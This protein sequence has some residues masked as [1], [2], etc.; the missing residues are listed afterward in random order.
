MDRKQIF[1]G[2][3]LILVFFSILSV[4]SAGEIDNGTLTTADDDLNTVYGTSNQEDTLGSSIG[5]FTSLDNL[6]DDSSESTIYL[7]GNYTYDDGDLGLSEG[8]TIDK[9]ITI[10]GQGHTLNALNEISIF[11]IGANNHVILKNI[12][13]INGNA[14]FGAAIK[15]D[16]TSSLEVID[17]TFTGNTAQTSGGAIYVTN[18]TSSTSNV[19]IT[20]STFKNNDAG[21][22]GAVYLNGN[23]SVWSSIEDSAFIDC[24]ASGDGGAIY[25]DAVNVA[26]K[27]VAFTNNVVGDDGGAIYWQGNNGII[28]NIT[29]TSNR[30]ISA[31]K[32]DGVNTSSTRGGTICLTG[33]NVTIS[34]STFTSSSAYMDEGKDTSK[35]DG[36]ALFVT[37]NG[38]TIKDTAF[39]DCNATNNGG[40]VYVIGNG[41]I[42]TNCTF[43]DCS[44]NDGGVIYVEGNGA[45]INYTSITGSNAAG[46]GGA[47]YVDGDYAMLYNTRF[48][49][50]IAAD[51]GGAIYWTGS[52]GTIYNITCIND[53]GISATKPDGV[54]TSS[55]RGGAICLTGS[56]VTISE[57]SFTSC[58]AYMD[59]GKDTSKVDGG[60]LFITGNGVNI[61]GTTFSDC[62]ATHDGGAIY[63]IGNNTSVQSCT[64]EDSTASDGGAVFVAG[65]DASISASEFTHNSADRNAMG[66]GGS[67]Q[68]EGDRANVSGCSFDNS[69]AYV[70]GV[71]YVTGH[72]SVIDN[73][74]F[75][76]ATA[77]EGGAIYVAGTNASISKSGFTQVTADLSGGAI[78]VEGN[79]TNIEECNFT[80]CKA[81]Y[82][83]GGAIYIEGLNTTVNNTRFMKCTASGTESRG[84]A[85]DVNG[86]DT[87]IYNS[88]FDENRAITGGAIYVSGHRAL[89]DNSSFEKDTSNNG[90]AI[91]VFGENATITAS[92]IFDCNATANGGGIDVEGDG[93]LIKGT[94]LEKCNSIKGAGGSIYITG[95]YTTIDDSNFTKSTANTDGGAILVAGNYALINASNFEECTA[96]GTTTTNGGGAI[97]I[98]GE[99]SHI[100]KSN[101]TNNKV[102]SN[103]ACGGTIYIEGYNATIDGSYFNRS[104][105]KNKG[106]IIFII[107][108]EAT[109]SSSVLANSSS[110]NSGGAIYVNGDN[111][112]IMGSEFANITATAHGGAIYIAGAYTDIDFSSFYNCT[113]LKTF[114]GGAIY[115]D[116]EGTTISYSNFTKS[117]AGTAGAISINGAN[118]TIDHCNL[119]DN[120]VTGSAGAIHVSGSNTIL[121]YNNFTNNIAKGGSGGALDI[122]GEN[123]SVL[124]SNFDHNDAKDNGGAINWIGGHGSDSI[125]GSL[126]TF[127]TCSGTSKGGGAIYWTA[128]DGI[129]TAGGLIKDTVF[130]NN[131]ALG[132]HGGAINWFHA[133][134]SVFDNCT[135]INNT[136]TSDG[137]ALYTGHQSG[138]GDNLS[139][140]NSRFYNNTAGLHGGAIANQMANSLIYNCDFN[141]NSAYQS[142]GSILMKEGA[143]DNS[144]ID[145]CNISN[146]QVFLSGDRWGEGGGSISIGGGDDNITISNCLITMSTVQYRYGGSVAVRSTNSSIINVTIINS[147]TLNEGAGS[148]YWSGSYGTLENVTIINSTSRNGNNVR[149]ANAGGV[150]WS[151][152]YGSINNL[153]IVNA[154]TTN[155]NTAG[156]KSA[157]A[158]AIHVSGEHTNLTNVNITNTSATA[159]NGNANGGGIYWTGQYGTLEN[160]SIINS[161][162]NGSVGG[163]I[164]LTGGNSHANNI[165]II[166]ST[167]NSSRSDKDALGGAIYWNSADSSMNNITIYNASAIYSY[168]G[169]TK[170][171]N[172]GAIYVT[173]CRINMTN[174]YIYNSSA[175]AV[176][177]R[178][179]GGAICRINANNNVNNLLANVTIHNAYAYGA[180]GGAIYWSAAGSTFNN[181]TIIN[182][183]LNST[184]HYDAIGGAIYWSAGSGTL[185]DIHITNSSTEYDFADGTLESSGGAIFINSG[186]VTLVD[187][188]INN[189]SAI[190]ANGKARGGAINNKQSNGVFV[191]SSISNSFANGQGGAIYW[192]GGS[193]TV[194]HITIINSSTQ[195]VGSTNNANGGAIYTSMGNLMHICIINSSARDNKSV[196]GGAVYYTGGNIVNLTVINSSAVSD[197]GNSYGGAVFWSVQ[198][199]R[200]LYNSTFINGSADY[201]GALYRESGGMN[202][203]NTEFANNTANISGGAV[204]SKGG[205]VNFHN[206]TFSNNKANSSGGAVY[207]QSITCYFH[208][209]AL[210]NNTAGYG[211]AIYY[212][213]HPNGRSKIENTEIINNTAIQGSAIFATELRCDFENVVLLDNQAHSMEFADATIGEDG[214]GNRYLS[215]IFRGYDNLL[216]A[217]W[218]DATTKYYSFTNVTY[219]GVNGRTNSGSKATPARSNDEVWINITVEMYDRNGN[220]L[221]NRTVVTDANGRFTYTFQ[222][223]SESDNSFKFYHEEDRYYTYLGD[224]KSNYTIVRIDVD[225]IFVGENATVNINLTDGVWNKLSGNVIV[226]LNDTTHTTIVVEV[227]NGTGSINVSGLEAGR[228][229]ATANFPGDSTHLGDTDWCVF[230]VIPIIDLDID[231]DINVTNSY[232]NVSDIIKYTITVHNDGPSKATGVNVTEVLDNHLKFRSANPSKGSY[233]SAGGYWYI[234]DLNNGQTVTLEIIAEVVKVGVISNSANVSGI[235]NESDYANNNATA[236]NVTALPVVDVA[237]VKTINVTTPTVNVTDKIE[238]AITVTNRG[239]CNATDV[240]VT[241]KLSDLLEV[242]SVRA[243]KGTYANDIWN[244]GDLNTTFAAKLTIVAK[245]KANGTIANAVAVHS[246]ENDTNLTN[247]NA[248]ITNRT[249]LN[250]VDLTVNKTSNVTG[251]VNVT[252]YV[253]FTITVHNNGPCAATNVNVTEKL[254]SHL[255][256]TRN[257]TENGYYNVNEGIWY[258]GNMDVGDTATLTLVARVMSN[259]T[260]SNV[261]S[262][263]SSENDTNK[264]DN[265]ANI[266]NITALNIVDLTV[267][268]WVNTSGPVNVTDKIEFRITVH[269]NGP[270]DATYVNVTEVL[271]PHL[272]FEDAMITSGYG[273]YDE[274]EGIWHIGNMANQST[275]VMTIIAK[276]VSNGT[277][278]NVA[279]AHS[280]END[281][282]KSNNNGTIKNITAL[283]IVD[284]SIIK[285]VNVTAKTL[286]FTDKLQFNLTVYNAGPCNATDVYV[287]EA[288]DSSLTF[289]SSTQSKGNYNKTTGI[290][291]IGNLNV[292]ETQNL[293]II[294]QVAFSGVI[295]NEVIVYSY[296]NDTNYANNRANIS[297][298]EVST[299]VDL[300]ISKLATPAGPVNVS[301]TITFTIIV[302][303]NSKNNA[304]GVYVEEILDSHLRLISNTTNK[305]YY[306]VSEGIWHIGNLE[307][308]VYDG[309]G[310]AFLNIVAEV[311]KAGNI[312][313][314][315][316]VSG[317]DTDSDLSNNNASIPNI[318]AYDIV[319]VSV[320]KTVNASGRVNV[321]DFIEF[322]I[323]VHNDGPSNATNVNVSEVLSP[324]LKIVSNATDLGYYDA[325]E[326]IWHVGTL[327]NQSTAT[328]TIKAQVISAGIIANVV[329]VNSTE[330]DTDKS[331]NRDNITNITAYDIVD[332]KI[333]KEV[334]VTGNV[335][336]TDVIQFNITVY[337][338]GPSNATNV[339]VSEALGPHLQMLKNETEKGYYDN[340]TGIWHIG[341]LLNQ[342]TAVL[343][344][345][346]RVISHGIIDNIVIVNST[347]NDTNLT[348]NMAEVML[349]AFNIVDVSVTKVSNVTGNVNVTDLIKFTIAVH[350]KGPC[351]ATGVNVT[352]ILDSALRMISCTP[353]EGTYDGRTWSGLELNAGETQTL[354]I[355]AMVEKPGIIKNEVNVSSVENDT[356]LSNNKANI[357]ELNATAY[358]DLEITKD[359]N[360]TGYVNVTDY[361]RFTITVTNNGP[362]N[363]SDV[364]VTEVLS[365]HL[366]MTYS[367]PTK[368]TYDG[369]IWN[370]GYLYN[371]QS[372]TLTIIAQVISNGTIANA[373]VVNTTSNDSNK[374]NNNDS[375][376]NITALP[377]VD[378][379]V[380][381]VVNVSGSVNVTDIIKFTITVH[382]NGPSDATDVNVSEVL[383]PHLRM[384]AN[385][386]TAGYYDKAAGIWHIGNLANQ[387]TAVLNITVQVISNGTIANVVAVTSSENDTNKSNNRN[388]ITNITAYNIVDLTVDKWVNVTGFVNVT[389]YVKFTITVTNNG[390]CNA[391]NVN[392]TE[393]LSPHLKM[394]ANTTTVGYYDK[395]AGVWHIGTLLNRSTAVLN[396]TAQVISNGTIA[397]AVTVAGTENDTNKSNNNFTIEN[398]T[399]VNIVDVSINKTVN[400][401]SKTLDFT[402]RLQFNVTVHN[403]GPCNATEVYVSE[404]LDTSLTLISWSAT[405]GTYNKTTGIWYI[406]NLNVG[407]SQNLTI[408]AQVAYSGIIENE[409][410]VYSFENDTNY[411]NNMANISAIEVSTE[412]DLEVTKIANTTG[413][414]NVSDKIRF[415]IS[416]NNR[417]GNN[418]SGVYVNEI[419]DSHLRLVS[420]NA[421]A[422]NYNGTVWYIGNM[423]GHTSAYLTIIAEI[424]KAG[425][426]SNAVYVSGYDNDTNKSNNNASVPNITALDILDLKITK[427]ANV[428]GFVNVTDIIRF[429]ITVTNNGPS[430]A[431]NVNVTEKLSSKLKLISNETEYGY[432]N[433]T[434]GIWHIKTLLNQSV[435][436]LNITAQ[437]I[438]IGTIS[439]AVSVNSTERDS[440]RSNN[441]DSIKNITALPIVDLA[442]SKTVNV[443]GNVNVTDTIKFTITVTNK[444]PWNA[445]NVNVS[446]ILS[447]NLKLLKNETLN[448]YY[449]ET[450]GVWHIGNLEN[451][452]TVVLNLT[453]KVNASGIIDNVV[454][455]YSAE[456]DTNLTNNV[457]ELI[458]EAFNIVDVSVNKT[459]NVTASDVQVT[460]I[461]K[462][463]VTV[464]NDGPCIATG[465]YVNEVLHPALRLVNYTA[466]KGSYNGK[467]WTGIDTLAIGENH[468]LTIV[469]E[470]IGEGIITNEAVAV[471]TENDTNLTNNRA[472]ISQ[473]KSTAYADLEVH[474][475]ANVTGEINVTDY[476]KFTISI[477]NNG[478]CNASNVIVNEALSTLLRMES[479]NA[480]KG[481]YNGRV[482]DIGEL[483]N[484][485]NHTLV[486]IAQV[487]SKG[488]ISNVVAA[489]SNVTDSNESN[490]NDS[491]ED[492]R[493]LPIVDLQITKTINTGDKVNVTDMVEYRITVANNGPSDATNVMVSEIISEYLNMTGYFA[494][495]GTYDGKTWTIGNLANGAS[496]FLIISAEVISNGTV[497]NIVRVNSTEND[498]NLSNNEANVTVEAFTIVDLSITKQVNVST[499]VEVTDMIKFTLTVHNAGPCNATNV[500]IKEAL[501]PALTLIGWNATKGVYKDL[502]TW[503]IGNMTVGDTETLEI[504]ARVDYSGVIVNEVIVFSNDQDIDF[505]NNVA[506]I[507]AITSSAHVD[508]AINKTS[509]VTGI[510]NVT[511][512]IEYTVS[513]HNNGPCN[514]SGV[515]VQEILDSHL[516]MVSATATHGGYDGFTWNIGYLKNNETATL[517]I[518]AQAISDGDITNDVIVAGYDE[519][520]DMSNN[521]ASV[522]NITA[523]PIVDLEILKTVDVIGDTVN[524]NDIIQ[525]TI[526]VRNNGPSDASDVKVN[527]RLSSHLEMMIYLTWIGYYDE[528]EGIWYIGDLHNQ[529][530]VD[531]IIQARV[532]S[533]GTIENAV[534]VTSY[535]NETNPSNN[536]ANITAITALPVVDLEITKETNATGYTEINDFV[537]FT[538][539]VTNNGP[540]DAT[541]VNVTEIPSQFLK[542]IRFNASKGYYNETDNVW[543]VGNLAVNSI[544]NLTITAQIIGD[545]L[546]SNYVIAD[547]PENDNNPYNNWAEV[548][549]EVLPLV[550]VSVEKTANVTDNVNVTDIIE[551]TVT[552]HNAGPSNATG[553]YVDETLSPLLR[554][555]SYNATAG[556]YD[557]FVWLIG[558]LNNGSTEKLTITAE[559][560]SAGIISNEV[561]VTSFITDINETNNYANISNITSTAF[562]DLSITKTVN[563][564]GS[565]N[566]TDTVEFIIFVK[567]NGPANATNVLVDEA[568]NYHLKLISYNA[569]TG[570][571]DGYTWVIGNLKNGENAT[572]TIAAKVVTSGNVTNFAAVSSSENESDSSDNRANITNLTAY[573]IVD[574][575]VHKTSNV[576]GNINVTDF[577]MFTVTVKNN[578]PSNATGVFVGEILSPHLRLVSY[579]ATAGSYNG[580]EW[581]IGNLNNGS[582]AELTIIAEVISAGIIENEVIAASVENDTDES[583][584]Y[585]N[586]TSVNATAY[587]DLSI[588]KKSNTTGPVNVSDLIEFVVTVENAGPANATNVIVS[589]ALDYHL[590][591]VSYNATVGGY[592]GFTWIVGNLDK[593]ASATLTIIARVASAGIISNVVFVKSDENDTNESDNHAD[594]PDITSQDI[595]DL[596]IH[597]TVNATANVN[598]TDLIKFSVTVKNNGPSDATGVFVDETL[599]PHLRLVSYNA[600]A[601]TYNG[602][603]WLIGNMANQST[604]ELTIV[605]E[606]I[607][608]GIIEN[609][610]A[611]T[612]VETDTNESNNHAEIPELNATAYVDLS[613][614]KTVNTTG[615]VNVTDKLE[616][617][618]T[619]KNNGPANATNVLVDEALNYHLKLL[620]YNATAGTYDGFTWVIGNL[621]RGA[622]AKLTIVAEVISAGNVTNEVAVKSTEKDT[623]TSNDNADITNITAYPIVDMA[624][625]KLVNVSTFNITDKIRFTITVYN[626]GPCSATGVYVSEILH[627]SLRLLSWDATKGAYDGYTWSIGTVDVGESETLTIIAEVISEG[628]ITNYVVVKSI[629]SDTNESNNH[630]DIANITSLP[631]V[632]LEITKVANATASLNV[633]DKILF[634]IIV[635]NKG[636]SDATGVKV[637]EILDPHLKLVTYGASTG[638]WDGRIWN[639]GNLKNGAYASLNIIAEAISNGTITNG[640]GIECNENDTNPSNNNASIGNIS[641]LPIVDLAIEKTVNVTGHLNVSDLVEF[642]ITVYNNGPSRA[643]G[644]NVSEVLDSHLKLISYDATAGSYDGVTW[645]VGSLNSA[646]GAK[647]AI[648]AQVISNGTISNAVAVSSNENDTN[649]SNN[650]ASTDNITAYPIVDL[651]I[652][653]KANVTG[654]VNVTD[655][656]KFAVTVH[657][658]GPSDATGVSVIEALDSHLK[659]ISYDATAGSYDGVAWTIGTLPGGSSESLTIIAEVISNGTI[660]NNVVVKSNENDTN[661][662]NNADSIEN[663]TS[664]PIVDLSVTKTVNATVANVGDNISYTIT[665]HN[666]GPNDAHNVNVTEKLS[667]YV[668]LIQFNATQGIYDATKNIW[669][670]G[671]LSNGSTQTLTL[672]VQIISRGIVE[673]SVTVKSD[674]ND[675]NMTNNNYVSDDVL[676]GKIDTP[677]DLA[678]YDITYGEDEVL[679]IRLPA[680]ATG[681]VNVTVGNRAYNDVPINNGIAELPVTDLA[682]GNYTVNVKYGGDGIFLANS[683]SSSFNVARLVPIITIEVEDIWVGETEVINVTVNAPGTVF[684][685]AYGITVEISLE[686]GVVTTD[687][688]ALS[689]KLNYLG[690]ATWNMINLPVGAYPAL[691]LYPGNEN[692]TSANA[693]DL[694]HVRDIPTSVVVTAKNIY[695]G[696]DALINIAVSPDGACG[697]VTVNVEGINYTLPLKN[698]KAT[699]TVSDLTAGVKNVSVWY[700]GYRMY[701]PSENATSFEVLKLKTPAKI[702]APEITVGEDGIITVSVPEDATGTITIKVD[703]KYYT[704][705]IVRGKARFYVPDLEEGEHG[706]DMFYSGDDKYLPV[707]TTGEIKVDAKDK[708]ETGNDTNRSV[709]A[710]EKY[711]GAVNLADY[712]TG[713]PIWALLAIMMAVGTAGLRRFR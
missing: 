249:A 74:T 539:T 88:D 684:V 551:F 588:A 598:V 248:S 300:E 180:S 206:A 168:A 378:L 712:P 596:E 591:L 336:V 621:N 202:V 213:N 451:Q 408:I 580:F 467:V 113:T 711:A 201:G 370:I 548:V 115:I 531:L 36:G 542:F 489:S 546:I 211:G 497:E 241:E 331:N 688:L 49:N 568:I 302:R 672:T 670:I 233:N 633:T 689:S 42:I 659:L 62:S 167:L 630:A 486:I 23:S 438:S 321:T 510:I 459:S 183:T 366:K 502:Y 344:I 500:Y 570:T 610:V 373:V 70:G 311:I 384:L 565:V 422:G 275:A 454:A 185:K 545:G 490:N 242:I 346:A 17:C 411:T 179:H 379:T 666:N 352:E 253:K 293:T 637:T 660:S 210:K 332:L 573:D 522:G 159:L 475:T 377:I 236:R 93:A 130:I 524:V 171:A 682:G 376:K 367:N 410:T 355:V 407:Q 117:F 107:G 681:T 693:S 100:S 146:S 462:F 481:T 105:A 623:N 291:H 112:T 65:N 471:S 52:N 617:V 535:E 642:I 325:G 139:I 209:S 655:K 478:P 111:T 669:Y 28:Y 24:S 561:I 363:A 53:R 91:Y 485:E 200:T 538:I 334:N 164:Y 699:L 345:T 147:T 90:G 563:A 543:Y 176:N 40:A 145:H 143:A 552:V 153:T 348:N 87:F 646:S 380:T 465:V 602:F 498:T 572:L 230:R 197:E 181:I 652:S 665:V 118:T 58:M 67:I 393:V 76:K 301:D 460:D 287:K 243:N 501:D 536:Y 375:I 63:I 534:N 678:A 114:A 368:G 470:V 269:N 267:N 51:D 458:F 207:A 547:S 387:S 420:S 258:V 698:G 638:K 432:Y 583:S 34:Q 469:A 477:T 285:T 519:D 589:E 667:D 290:W 540:S 217:I 79:R 622:E 47:M 644:V 55:T 607:S 299:E 59:A 620:S 315:V 555:I 169:G 414:L 158:G 574:L 75:E 585:D 317:F 138:G 595:V 706:I 37:G 25:I 562:V 220:L 361:V 396:I 590:K 96:K 131:S 528:G 464:R 371:R 398:I 517:T 513:V 229:N 192:T 252:D 433:A 496:V 364:N 3:C 71:I 357:T 640:V 272:K 21:F 657:N 29:C 707:N 18:S 619:V 686:N 149:D 599:S 675:T 636:P 702:D 46:D 708:N 405:G 219:W 550:D 356:N 679:V 639:I 279:V 123:A 450:E 656:I 277:I 516:S 463:T 360:V 13:F 316:N 162:V 323:T 278:A 292:G 653:K 651:A 235:E 337:N 5:N 142:G 208:D 80:S 154:S 306:N 1:L 135:F 700:A 27:N 128:G 240:Y 127:N 320:T 294:A 284:V 529:E 353:S 455:A 488:T 172:G 15:L 121:E 557:G 400:I 150:Y 95:E 449:N 137:G 342:S 69:D 223:D 429:T 268:K 6:I 624:I 4:A 8:I 577:I 339:N 270:C 643:T 85:I 645:T 203:Y 195:G 359:V 199:I 491:I 690:N 68:I 157:N 691:A 710:A 386:T 60:A 439:N 151:G 392:V 338:A 388:N 527:E 628:N 395:A 84:G 494:S 72:D 298:I 426:I 592:D 141:Y 262:V 506:A 457:A 576:T 397:N 251:L 271:S 333:T 239:P 97:Y 661:K 427:E 399:A 110:K 415:D 255:K 41:T 487:I 611:V 16:G 297:A 446:E 479:Y 499:E 260:I 556:S 94:S 605:A 515:Y 603:V 435:A 347:E 11:N 32:A 10:D 314:S 571:Y 244:I 160:I 78:Y 22:G 189:S 668:S 286:E 98:T 440:N 216:N 319:D 198:N 709:N 421:T 218:N 2:I 358:V 443:T 635:H 108:E 226:T 424:I 533:N 250:I 701:L 436:V 594:I 441:R 584:N 66:H 473:I 406:G 697:N 30:G 119:Y 109:I 383:S 120:E 419:L 381:K 437:V 116:D 606:V 674:E 434:T 601:G 205:I 14:T 629:E 680:K 215:A 245:V 225:D 509:N 505:T 692:Y 530:Y 86:N 612:G 416:V 175:V 9:S 423:E 673:N 19:K 569:T 33:D 266:T 313:N 626:N 389:D 309:Q 696:E 482:W 649:K 246:Y 26:L 445:S 559:V 581:I 365:P 472:N 312:S 282:N 238:F 193:P 83:H 92:D 335:N 447:P 256:L 676:A 104:E 103:S 247:N 265:A 413:P 61:T 38:I 404:I 614:S 152:T 327:H 7:E 632:D 341:T 281:T 212:Y 57:S 329:T 221:D 662:S 391:T 456:N 631:I 564:S 106:G 664:L 483:K 558:N 705:E 82:Y 204:Y 214:S 575:E 495:R 687:V 122:G 425:N 428:T 45:L 685:T 166:N 476:I 616:F 280:Y 178:A 452:S 627:E 442:I 140:I 259:G 597:K 188:D 634:T 683:T 466:S 695:V 474:K 126:F 39:S 20:G 658:S 394:I 81:N 385:V 289:I 418:A 184:G 704:A 354:T 468:T 511:G 187:V 231:K 600:T 273:Y 99:Q 296:E 125:I 227:I 228:Y 567:N 560:V 374:S 615:P 56:D 261:V 593:G 448:G 430:N 417:G 582:A 362:C 196:Y 133:L 102:T 43:D 136:S 553:V 89:I 613:I 654:F 520:T 372:V 50:N 625:T 274:S 343:R 703:G 480:T 554:M 351:I 129:I 504:V 35:V 54:N 305:G 283:P 532:V 401:T 587:A 64:F 307:G 326:G 161:F 663:I 461:I 549:V 349:E 308:Y 101:F 303:N 618:I 671:K 186:S 431:T 330:R 134:D 514:A 224:S 304:S 493:A 73:S 544:A 609:A 237:V 328:L 170:E 508:L 322:T 257:E 44:A 647:L 174:V 444:G 254:S 402:D 31:T 369:S 694:F 586:I 648:T 512:L 124:Y 191:N 144:V 234:G 409:V 190:A 165:L 295:E 382:N 148:I 182:S 578:G 48:I 507:D 390:P 340:A 518:V 403:A 525:F 677:I 155:N 521:N 156:S 276:V 318:T 194:N 579:N 177:G 566:V 484:G 650:G 492:I 264:S 523:L 608:E 77:T 713:N 263:K 503:V 641:V 604:A 541:D 132:K 324:H 412:V 350:N 288:L 526:R 222:A 163:G 232:V 12:N 537:E 173:N 310:Y 453:V